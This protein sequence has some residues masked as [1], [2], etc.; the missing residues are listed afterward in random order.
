MLSDSAAPIPMYFILPVWLLA[1]C[2][3][4]HYI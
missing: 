4:R 1:R 3:G 2:F